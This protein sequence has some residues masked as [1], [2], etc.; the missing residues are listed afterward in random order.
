ILLSKLIDEEQIYREKSSEEL[1]Y[2]LKKN[3]ARTIRMNWMCPKKP[4][5]RVF[6]KCGI[7][8]DNMSLAYDSENLP[9]SEDKWNSTVFFSKQFG[10]Y[11]WPE[12]ISVVVFAKRPQINRPKLNECEK[13]IVAAFE[14]PE[15]YGL[16]ITLLLIEKRDLPELKESTVWIVK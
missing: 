2:W 9:N 3:K 8:P 11:K 14:N 5:E 10:C 1:A 13:A 6:L 4:Q 15:F 16:W 12:T 7:R